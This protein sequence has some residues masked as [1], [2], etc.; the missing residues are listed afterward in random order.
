MAQ[1]SG[2]AHGDGRATA[3][4]ARATDDALRAR[5]AELEALVEARRLT[6][7]GL[8]AQLTEFQGSPTFAR[9]R[10]V[11][12]ERHIAA[13]EAT[14]VFRYSAIPRRAYTTLRRAVAGVLHRG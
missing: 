1:L 10:L 12:A 8:A 7:V 3:D 14:K 9:G 13:L 2:E 4:A 6:I 5:I 11:E